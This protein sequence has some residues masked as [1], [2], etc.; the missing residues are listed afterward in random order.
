MKNKYTEQQ[1]QEILDAVNKTIEKGPWDESSF[2][3]VIG[4]NLQSIRDQLTNFLDESSNDNNQA[5]GDLAHRVA[6]RCGQQEVFIGLYSS[7]GRNLTSWE[8]IIASLPTQIIARPIYAEEQDVQAIMR[9]KEKPVNE[10]YVSI[11]VSQNDILPVSKDKAPH[12]KLGKTLI[13]LKSKAIDLKNINRFV[14]K[15]G[16]YQYNNGRLIK[17]NNQEDE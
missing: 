15:S 16:I 13:S 9:H 3:R 1:I 6:Q 11:Y 7:E 8:R 2:L 12:D 4:K 17:Q 10:G 5:S 14:H